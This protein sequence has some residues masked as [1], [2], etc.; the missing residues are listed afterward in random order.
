MIIIVPSTEFSLRMNSQ[1][2]IHRKLM[3]VYDSINRICLSRFPSFYL[4]TYLLLHAPFL[5]P[6]R[7]NQ[8][9]KAKAKSYSFTTLQINPYDERETKE[10]ENNLHKNR[11]RMHTHTLSLSFPLARSPKPTRT[12]PQEGR[13]L[14]SQPTQPMRSDGKQN[15]TGLSNTNNHSYLLPQIPLSLA[16]RRRRHLVLFSCPE[17]PSKTN[18]NQCLFPHHPSFIIPSNSLVPMMLLFFL[19]PETQIP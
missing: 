4:F 8:K 15:Q 7:A 9:P 10:K 6:H 19:F 5:T 3:I 17:I 2:H 13:Y 16:L 18:K 14:Y 1:T 12:E 11:T